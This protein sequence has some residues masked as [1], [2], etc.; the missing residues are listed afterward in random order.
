M[1]SPFSPHKVSLVKPRLVNIDD[2]HTISKCF[3][4]E[5]C[6]LLSQNKASR[7]ITEIGDL[8]DRL[9]PSSNVMS[10]YLTNVMTFDILI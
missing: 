5:L 4:H 2:S 10:K 9:I 6:I 8:F 7:L 3:E 1:H